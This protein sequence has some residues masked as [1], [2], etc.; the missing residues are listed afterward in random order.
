[1]VAP[2]EAALS[3]SLDA[4]SHFLHTISC[5]HARLTLLEALALHPLW[6]DF[7]LALDRPLVPLPDLMAMCRTGSLATPLPKVH[8]LATLLLREVCI[9]AC[10]RCSFVRA[11]ACVRACIFHQQG[12]GGDLASRYLFSLSQFEIFLL[13]VEITEMVTDKHTR[14]PHTP[15][16]HTMHTKRER[17]SR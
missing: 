1:M 7:N 2:S 8:L 9:Y 11:C 17:I 14:P 5:S 15:S 13:Y 16:L 12:G 3:A 10:V 4:A 6:V